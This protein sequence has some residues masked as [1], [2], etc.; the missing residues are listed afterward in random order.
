MILKNSNKNET[1]NL[2]GTEKNGTGHQLLNFQRLY[3]IMLAVDQ[4]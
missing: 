2:Y 1:D 4:N 3:R